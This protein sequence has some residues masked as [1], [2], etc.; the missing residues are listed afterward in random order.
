MKKDKTRFKIIFLAIFFLGLFGG[1]K[2]SSADTYLNFDD[3]TPTAG[4]DTPASTSVW[5]YRSDISANASAGWRTSS[6]LS[7]GYNQFYQYSFIGTCDPGHMGAEYF[8]FPDIAAGAECYSGNCLRFTITGQK[9]PNTNCSTSLGT[10]LYSKE[11]YVAAG[12]PSAVY[13]GSD[14]IGMAYAYVSKD[15][16]VSRDTSP[17]SSI[18]DVT[19]KNRVSIY[20]KLPPGENNGTG[21]YN[22]PVSGTFHFNP[23]TDPNNSGQHFYNTS[24]LEGKTNGWAKIEMDETPDGNNAGQGNSIYYPN[25]LHTMWQLYFTS[26]PYDGGDVAPWH[27]WVDNIEFTNDTYANQ[28]VETINGL[29]FMYNNDSNKTWQVSFNQKYVNQTSF[30]TYELRYSFSPITN[31]NWAS[32]TPAHIQADSRYY[33]QDRTDGKF[34]LWWPYYKGVWAPF[35]LA[36]SGDEAL[37]TAGTTIYFAV[38]DIT[39]QWK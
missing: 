27:M 19:N 7:D 6:R 21:G 35:R 15:N 23:F 30:G 36:S 39:G 18:A 3:F 26:L 32:A 31:E 34:Q 20:V 11:Q 28:N 9:D 24:Y 14:K 10:P 16:G 33:I 29:S 1:T 25:L 8:G 5:H 13:T 22:N 12:G 17:F 38:K 37:L 4:N 2:N